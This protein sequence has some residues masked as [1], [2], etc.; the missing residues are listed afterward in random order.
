MLNCAKR[1]SP[2]NGQIMVLRSLVGE[3]EDS[4]GENRDGEFSI[5]QLLVAR[6]SRGLNF[7][8]EFHGLL[9]NSLFPRRSSLQSLTGIPLFSNNLRISPGNLSLQIT[10]HSL[11]ASTDG[12]R[13]DLE[14][15]RQE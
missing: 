9:C 4:P 15:I 13:L 8:S 11:Q 3:V 7:E 1:S 12:S 2:S 6:E 5:P 10:I 14:R